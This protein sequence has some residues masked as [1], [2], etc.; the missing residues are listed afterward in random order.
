ML[1]V[2]VRHTSEILV[3]DLV[4]LCVGIC[5]WR[6]ILIMSLSLPLDLLF[7]RH[8]ILLMLDLH[9]TS[10]LVIVETILLIRDGGWHTLWHGDHVGR[11]LIAVLVQQ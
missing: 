11:H 3:H 10:H 4:Q 7:I 1:D 8:L 9:T 6:S 5:L 2:L